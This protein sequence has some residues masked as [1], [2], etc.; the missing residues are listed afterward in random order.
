MKRTK[1]EN[2]KEL[3]AVFVSAKC[4]E[5]AQP[6]HPESPARVR[7]TRDYLSARGLS[8]TEPLTCNEND[9]RLAHSEELIRAV[10]K[11]EFSD[12]DTPAL[13]GIYDY[14]LLAVSGALSA[15][16]HC[17]CGKSAFSLMRPPGHHAARNSLGGFCYFN[18]I[19][20]AVKKGVSAGRKASI[21]DIDCHH[22]NGT[23]DIFS[24]EGSV[25]YAS[26][27][28]SPLYP[29]TGLSSNGNCLNF[30]LAAGTGEKQYLETLGTAMDEIRR[31]SPDIIAV[32]A[33]FDTH[34]DDPLAGMELKETTYME[35]A[36][37]IASLDMP[38]FAVLEG[39]YGPKLP[40]CV[41]NFLMGF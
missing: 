12:P 11:G 2:E 9:I 25:L 23:Q 24:G 33:G 10:K 38:R 21:I 41:Y 28:Q 15:M 17:L 31:F 26:L 3:P 36:K 19:A 18:N 4:W 6:G 29:G 30:P 22:G 34:A 37:M 1:A 35:I 16:E 39:G 32:S 8:F 5:Y 20:V 14:A 40:E 13:P 27:H 7:N